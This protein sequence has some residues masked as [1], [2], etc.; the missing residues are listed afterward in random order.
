V[1][2]EPVVAPRHDGLT[3]PNVVAPLTPPNRITPERLA[4]EARDQQPPLDD[5]RAAPVLALQEGGGEG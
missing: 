5:L 4:E 2:T 1:R 3:G